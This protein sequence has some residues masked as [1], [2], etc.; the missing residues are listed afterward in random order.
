MGAER[1]GCALDH[2]GA[3]SIGLGTPSLAAALRAVDSLV[4][5]SGER[6]GSLVTFVDAP[7]LVARQLLPAQGARA[8]STR[9]LRL[10]PHRAEYI[11]FRVT[12]D[13]AFAP[14]QL[15]THVIR[16]LELSRL[17]ESAD[18]ALASE[19]SRASARWVFVAARAL[20]T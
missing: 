5:P 9:D 11:G 7:G 3:R 4:G 6:A 2:R 20:T 14:P 15:P 8:P 12:C 18:T 10:E 17:A 19:R 1:R 16:E 13:R